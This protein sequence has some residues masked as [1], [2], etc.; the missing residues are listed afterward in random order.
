MENKDIFLYLDC[1]RTRKL[2]KKE[3]YLNQVRPNPNLISTYRWWKKKYDQKS[4]HDITIL[5][6]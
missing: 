1:T 6:Y 4:F 5:M 2:I 3:N